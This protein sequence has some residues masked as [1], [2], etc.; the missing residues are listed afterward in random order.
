MESLKYYVAT[1]YSRIFYNAFALFTDAKKVEL[2]T[3]MLA[4]YFELLKGWTTQLSGNLLQYQSSWPL[5]KYLKELKSRLDAT[6]NETNQL[7]SSGSFRVYSAILGS[8]TAFDRALPNTK[9]D[10]FTLIHQNLL[11]SMNALL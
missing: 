4:P 7:N 1:I 8:T 2:F 3:Q 5:D 11:T 10:V 9:E 6:G